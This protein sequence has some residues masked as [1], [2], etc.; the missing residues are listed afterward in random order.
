[1]MQQFFYRTFLALLLSLPLQALPNE[2]ELYHTKLYV[3]ND[4]LSQQDS[5]YTGG[6]KLDLI[7]KINN[8]DG[9]YNLLLAGD[10]KVYLFRSFSLATQIYTP[11]DLTKK[12]PI[13]DDWSYAAWTYVE[14][15]VHKSTKKTLSSLL[16]KVGVV[17]PDAGG[18][19]FQKAVHKW[20]GSTDPQGWS[21]QL[22]NE[23]TLN[24]SYIYKERF[25]FGAPNGYGVALVPSAQ[26]DLGNVF[27][28]ATV[29]CFGR[30]GYNIAKDF[31]LATMSVGGESGIPVYGEQK[32]TLQK[33]WSASFNLAL[34]SSLVARDMFVEGNTF[35]ESIVTH[36]RRWLVG[37]VGLGFSLRY[38][39]FNI[40]FMQTY[41][42]P[43]AKDID[44]SKAVGTLLFTYFY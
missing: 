4:L 14:V 15:G 29:G 13:P 6:M 28:Q 24:V 40:D 16:L 23:M 18:E 9:L 44:R 32:R 10:S 20:T 35:K 8:P 26:I 37:Y 17:G 30:F 34:Y 31:G 41:N 42:T 25:S 38:R 36:E 5:Q 21:N 7:Y 27:T 1:M 2:W 39:S 11:E 3:E 43:K 22:Y 33:R 12:E 19:Q